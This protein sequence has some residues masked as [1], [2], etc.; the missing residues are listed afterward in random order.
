MEVYESD[1]W[2]KIRWN[3]R[4]MSFL[5]AKINISACHQ[6]LVNLIFLT[7][8]LISR[9][10]L[11]FQ[12]GIWF[13]M[14][15]FSGSLII[16]LYF[17]DFRTFCCISILGICYKNVPSGKMKWEISIQKKNEWIYFWS[18][19]NNKPHLHHK[20]FKSKFVGKYILNF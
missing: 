5:G 16:S 4:R 20:P 15:H 1:V 6:V 9:D 12:F 19:L 8:F 14:L 17:S 18:S 13:I 11:T 7:G 2:V 3:L 10:K